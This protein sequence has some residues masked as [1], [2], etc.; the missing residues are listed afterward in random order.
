M[1]SIVTG[2]NGFIG[3]H[4]VDALIEKGH[5]VTVIDNLSSPFHEKFHYN[6]QAL[7]L[8]LDINDPTVKGFFEGVDYVFHL[9][10]E[11]RIQPTIEDPVLACQTNYVGTANV[12]QYAREAGAKR[13]MFS[14]TS[15]A[16]GLQPPP[17]RESLTPD[18]L[19]PYS[20][21]KVSAERLC[22][23][24]HDLFGLETVVFRYFNVYGP[25]E[26]VK[27]QYAPVVGR[28]LKQQAAGELLTVVKPGTQTRDFVHVNDIVRANIAAMEAGSEVA[29][30]DVYNIG[31]GESI[32][33]KALAQRIKSAINWLPERQG[34]AKH[35]LADISKSK[36][37]LNW[38]PQE[39]LEEYIKNYLTQ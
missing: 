4:I 38:E 35:T 13:V 2:G 34:E 25:R 8:K 24:Y 29:N 5:K 27:G 1:K 36:K 9:A 20:V 15:S 26:P 22:K 11:S 7:Y 3:G 31:T 14:S 32:S 16:Y 12:L 21:T 6:D 28:F 23:M 19:N 18:P 33:I 17:H 39:D 37:M 30:G 10:A